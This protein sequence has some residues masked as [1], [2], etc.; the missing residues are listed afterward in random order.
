MKTIFN[1]EVRTKP[2]YT[3]NR[4]TKVEAIVA[5]KRIE[6]KEKQLKYGVDLCIEN[7]AKD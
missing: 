7:N 1:L 5:R 2:D 3:S 4:N 6:R